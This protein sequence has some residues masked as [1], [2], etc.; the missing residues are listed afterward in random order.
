MAQNDERFIK[1]T[2]SLMNAL[3]G[4]DCTWVPNDTSI[5]VDEEDHHGLRAIIKLP[6][7]M[8]ISIV[9]YVNGN[10]HITFPATA[11]ANLE[12]IYPVKGKHNIWELSD[13]K[14]DRIKLTEGTFNEDKLRQLIWAI[15]C[16]VMAL[17]E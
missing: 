7:G 3:K 2:A 1:T 10:L 8:N 13:G 9:V 6:N 16:A 17:Y 14:E 11:K 4:L 12:I 5:A 15:Y